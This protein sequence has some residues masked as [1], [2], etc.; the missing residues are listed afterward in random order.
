LPNLKPGQDICACLPAG[1][2]A[3]GMTGQRLGGV[4]AANEAGNP[5][6][7]EG[8]SFQACPDGKRR[9]FIRIVKDFL[10]LHASCT[11]GTIS[12]RIE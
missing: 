8:Q 4:S 3:N 11:A 12:D 9:A 2:Q 6:L 10:S 7:Y 5:V 1:R